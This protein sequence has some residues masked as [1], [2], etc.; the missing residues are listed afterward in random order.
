MSER[1]NEV[2]KDPL[3]VLHPAT[4][5]VPSGM[6]TAWYQ[7]TSILVGKNPLTPTALLGHSI[8]SGQMQHKLGC[9]ATGMVQ[10]LL[11]LFLFPHQPPPQ[12]P[13][14]SPEVPA[15]GWGE[16]GDRNESGLVGTC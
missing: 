14:L 1:F 5:S 12:P 7:I 3:S 2:Y 10:M 15:R 6:S 11:L 9:K 4:P 8:A 16:A 13:I